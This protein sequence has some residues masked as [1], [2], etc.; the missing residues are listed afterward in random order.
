MAV[1]DFAASA[2]VLV[3]SVRDLLGSVHARD[4]VRAVRVLSLGI[5]Q[6]ERRV[7][8]DAQTT[9]MSWQEIGN[10]YGVTRQSVHRR[11]A[12]DSFL[13]SGA[14]EELMLELD[15]DDEPVPA[16]RQ[17]AKRFRHGAR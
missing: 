10:V 16:L 13:S 15:V 7:L 4:R 3:E 14:F 8:L 2:D 5:Q 12:D 11:F 1:D 6:L 17:A 9:G